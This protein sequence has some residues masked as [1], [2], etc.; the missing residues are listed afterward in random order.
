M[1]HD[2]FVLLN[3][4]PSEPTQHDLAELEQRFVAKVV[5]NAPKGST[6]WS[7]PYDIV[8]Y[9]RRVKTFR[10]NQV[11]GSWQT[12]YHWDTWSSLTKSWIRDTRVDSK[13]FVELSK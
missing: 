9:Y 10:Q 4:L 3:D 7:S 11:D 12:L 1:N 13:N 8:T 2:L 6:H 5:A